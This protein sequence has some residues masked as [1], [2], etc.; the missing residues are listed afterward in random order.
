MMNGVTYEE[1]KPH[2]QNSSDAELFVSHFSTKWK[3]VTD[4]DEY[5]DPETFLDRQ[6]GDCDDFAR[7]IYEMLGDKG[8]EV[9]MYRVSYWDDRED[10]NYNHAVVYY[11][12]WP[13]WGIFSNYSRY[14]HWNIY[15]Y[16]RETRYEE[17]EKETAYNLWEAR[18]SNEKSGEK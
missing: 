4:E 9:T 13:D 3:D 11:K 17:W 5:V 14:P 18:E 16:V 10:R 6:A 8:Y 1:V 2:I 7:F 15:D 12:K